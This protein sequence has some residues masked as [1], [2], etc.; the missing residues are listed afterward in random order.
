MKILKME[1]EINEVFE[2]GGK[3]Y[4]TKEYKTSCRLC[5]F[6]DRDD[7]GIFNCTYAD[8]E[9]RRQVF[10]VEVNDEPDKENKND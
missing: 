5:S 10:F 1:P 6:G 3:K 7:C 4:K 2:Y 9:D 8:R